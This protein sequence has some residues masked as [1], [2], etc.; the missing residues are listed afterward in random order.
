VLVVE[1]QVQKRKGGME[2]KERLSSHGFVSGEP[3]KR[4]VKKCSLGPSRK[5]IIKSTRPRRNGNATEEWN[6]KKRRESTALAFPNW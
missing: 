6:P 2:A 1:G 3:R 5:Y 4:P